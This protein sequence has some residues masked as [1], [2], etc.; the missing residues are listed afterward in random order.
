MLG[1]QARRPSLY[2]LKAE[3]AKIAAPLLVVAG[4]EDDATL[5]PGLLMKRTI[6]RAGLTV[7]PWSGHALNLEEAAL[8]NRV[9][10]DFFHQV[11]SG[12][13]A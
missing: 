13:W 6:P 4:D 8:F 7:F 3:M 5:E 12:R 9:L 10:E 1:Y 2:D 11:E